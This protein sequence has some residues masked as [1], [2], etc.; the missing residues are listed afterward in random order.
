MFFQ[1]FYQCLFFDARRNRMVKLD[2]TYYPKVSS[3]SKKETFKI[4]S[5]YK[6]IDFVFNDEEIYAFR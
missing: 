2:A 3:I 1:D 4:D 5:K 6:E